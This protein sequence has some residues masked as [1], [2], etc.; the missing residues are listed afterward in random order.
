MKIM[1]HAL[2][3]YIIL[4]CVCAPLFS[5]QP[6][7][8]Y[9]PDS[10]AY[11]L[12]AVNDSYRFNSLPEPVRADSNLLGLDV[13]AAGQN[14]AISPYDN[15]EDALYYLVSPFAR[16]TFNRR[17]NMTL[18][19]NVENIRRDYL[20]PERSYWA[21]TFAGH[22]GDYDVSAITYRGKYV[23]I[24]AGRDYLQPGINL[25]E[26]LLFSR[27]AYAHDQISIHLHN[28][29]LVLSSVYVSPTS[30]RE[31]GQ[32]YNRHINLHRLALRLPWG[33]IALNDLML[34]GG[35]NQGVDIMAFNPLIFLY[36]YRKNKKHLDGNNIMSLELYLTHTDYF[37]FA[38]A[39]LDDY[40]ADR[41][42][43]TDLEPPEWGVNLTVGKKELAPAL[44]WKL[45]YTRLANRTFNAPDRALEKYIDKNYP[46]GHWLGNNFWEVKTSFVYMPTPR[47]STDLTFSYLEYGD[48]ALYAPF[49]KDYENYTVEQ[50]YDENFPYGRL[51]TQ[52]G[53]TVNTYYRF[54]A[55]WLLRGRLGYWPVNSILYNRI[56][57][58]LS[59]AYRFR[60]S[61]NNAKQ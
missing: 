12:P 13:V 37:L 30:T 20:Y 56:S 50:G 25:Y 17:I 9:Q 43:S 19:V 36:P 6:R 3:I 16:Y 42:V 26:N 7:F 44:M 33:Y 31:N 52:A 60:F 51:H 38:E 21:D 23:T 18:R 53:V 27:F 40:Q 2:K 47:W 57:A 14:G 1:K 29:Y 55:D 49:N 15:Y 34:Y 54:S 58:G 32:L 46:I 22:R 61:L 4:L 35:I 41:K 39:L 8:F 11:I 48:E 5:Q 45:N 24:K 10:A 59:L 28:R